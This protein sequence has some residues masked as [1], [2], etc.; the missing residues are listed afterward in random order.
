MHQY[1]LMSANLK[2]IIIPV[3]YDSVLFIILY[4]LIIPFI[5]LILSEDMDK[6]KKIL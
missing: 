6:I 1:M 5:I 3:I 2:N 4:I